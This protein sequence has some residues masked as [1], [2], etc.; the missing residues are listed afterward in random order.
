MADTLLA[1]LP[2]ELADDRAS[3][4]LITV[5]DWPVEVALSSLPDVVRWTRYPPGLDENA[6][7]AR[8]EARTRGAAAGV[9]GRYVL[10]DPTGNVVGTAGIAMNKQHAPEVFYALLPAGR[11]RG[12]A[13]AATVQL[14]EWALGIGHDVVVLKTML[15]NTVS[16]A[17]AC[18]SGFA[19]VTVETVAEGD[20]TVRLRRWE[21]LPSVTVS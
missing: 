14:T 19:A 16:E 11:G 20:T 21:R 13:T 1:P 10:R 9:G 8:I 2:A 7:R 18:R 3:L 17:V 6:A 12:L 4:R 5:D 15:G